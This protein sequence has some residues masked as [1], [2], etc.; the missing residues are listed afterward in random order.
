VGYKN[1]IKNHHLEECDFTFTLA[2]YTEYTFADCY[3]FEMLFEYKYKVKIRFS[4][5]NHTDYCKGEYTPTIHDLMSE[6]PSKD[7][8]LETNRLKVIGAIRSDPRSA[9][10]VTCSNADLLKSTNIEEI[11]KEIEKSLIKRRLQAIDSMPKEMKLQLK[12]I[13]SKVFE[14]WKLDSVYTGQIMADCF[15]VCVKS[16]MTLDFIEQ[17]LNTNGESICKKMDFDG[18]LKFTAKQKDRIEKSK[19]SNFARIKGYFKNVATRS[20]T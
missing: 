10:K 19:V 11:V 4:C 5:H 14:L 6:V 2:E 12:R 20:D 13:E 15:N 8:C 18:F 3:T 17:I 9:Y 16:T 1:W 7:M